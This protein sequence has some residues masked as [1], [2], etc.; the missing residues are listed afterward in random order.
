M[1]AEGN[2]HMASLGLQPH[3]D[4]KAGKGVNFGRNK[5]TILFGMS[6]LTKKWPENKA[7]TSPYADEIEGGC[8]ARPK[9]KANWPEA[10]EDRV[11]LVTP[12]A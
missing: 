8:R 4:G 10:A 3:G 1:T 2:G 9:N 7:I 5:A 11:G 6:N 12:P